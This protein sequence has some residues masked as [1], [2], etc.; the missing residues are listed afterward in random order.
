VKG[1]VLKFSGGA[2]LGGLAS[3]PGLRTWRIGPAAGTDST[4]RWRLAW[5]G[6]GRAQPAGDKGRA[7]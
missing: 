2:C 4:C 3:L 7:G 1:G 5:L 6:P